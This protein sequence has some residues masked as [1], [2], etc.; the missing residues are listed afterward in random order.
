MVSQSSLKSAIGGSVKIDF[1]PD[2]TQREFLLASE[3][4]HAKMSQ[5]L[6]IGRKDIKKFACA[7]NLRYGLGVK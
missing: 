7:P 1:L 6:G 3:N 2:A 5:D 4:S